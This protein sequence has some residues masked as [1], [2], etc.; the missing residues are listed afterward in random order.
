MHRDVG[1]LAEE[2][3]DLLGLVRREVVSH[4]MDILALGLVRHD[5]GQEGHELSRRLVGSC[6][7]EHFAGLGVEG[8]L[9]AA[10][11]AFFRPSAR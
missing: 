4:H 10:C 6:L 8:P 5:V 3:L 7:A 2:V 1:V 11:F 9:K